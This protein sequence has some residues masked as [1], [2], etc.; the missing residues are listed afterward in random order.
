MQALREVEKDNKA[1]LGFQREDMLKAAGAVMDGDVE[2]WYETVGPSPAARALQNPFMWATPDVPRDPA[3]AVEST[4]EAAE[5]AR[6]RLEGA[7][8]RKMNRDM[9]KVCVVSFGGYV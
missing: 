9:D 4:R 8:K 1:W 3:L 5:K 6:V 2:G 7:G